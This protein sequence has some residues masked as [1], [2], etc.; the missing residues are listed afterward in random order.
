L[1]IAIDPDKSAGA[2]FQERV[3]SLL[4]RITS[5]GNARLPGQRRLAARDD[6]VRNGI[7]VEQAALDG[8][9]ALAVV[10]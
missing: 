9:R 1:I 6:A 10:V 8:I 2:H 4:T 3:E 5:N 7:A